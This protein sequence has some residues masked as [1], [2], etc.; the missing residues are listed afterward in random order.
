MT[1]IVLLILRIAMTLALY[2]LLGWAFLL[3]WRTLKQETFLLSNRKT[4]PL[5]LALNTP[6][7]SSQI[8]RFTD[9]DIIVGRDPDCECVLKDETIS[10]RHIRF[11]Y[12]HNQWWGED[13]GSRN[14]TTLNDAA[15]TTP[16]ILI[17]GDIVK[18]GKSAIQVIL[19]GE[20]ASNQNIP[21]QDMENMQ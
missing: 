11:T 1:G 2:T 14:G 12:H 10:A 5:F 3:M 19:E 13:L 18:C 7:S 16:T 9:G 6:E 4:A 21:Q 17:H 8:L 20:T 15:L